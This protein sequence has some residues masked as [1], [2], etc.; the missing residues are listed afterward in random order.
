MMSVMIDTCEHR[1][2]ATA[3]LAGAYLYASLENFALLKLEGESV[4][5]ICSVCAK[6]KE[7]VT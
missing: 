2:A 5:I 4:E 6:Y 1:D 3:D 7:F